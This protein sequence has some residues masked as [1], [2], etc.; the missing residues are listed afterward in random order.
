MRQL[1]GT[2]LRQIVRPI[3]LA[4]LLMALLLPGAVPMANASPQAES[5]KVA[6]ESAWKKKPMVIAHRGGRKWAPENTMIAFKKSMN[7]GCDG[8][9]LDIHRCKSGELVVIHDETLDRTTDGKGL[10]KDFT[11]DEIKKLDAGKWYAKEF[12]GERVPLLSEVLEAFDGKM[13]INIEIKNTP[14]EYVGIEDDL[15][16]LLRKYKH[17]EKIMIS[18]F[19]HELI[20]RIHKISPIYEVAFLDASIIADVGEYGKKLGATAW[21]AAH[22]ELRPDAVKRAQK[23]GLSVNVWTVDGIPDW[24]RAMEWN[25]DGIVTDDPAG[26]IDFLKTDEAKVSLN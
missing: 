23:A 24:K 16:N 7:A 10:V 26:L 1:P 9:E 22:Y 6:A 19:D 13:L 8:V 18:S 5:T 4:S 3:V 14:I 11:Y 17:P 25:V 15:I 12:E 2:R 20:R 21:N